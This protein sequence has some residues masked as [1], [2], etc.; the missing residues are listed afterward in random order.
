MKDLEDRLEILEAT[1]ERVSLAVLNSAQ[2]MQ[3]NAILDDLRERQYE[4]RMG[5]DL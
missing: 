2:L 1:L 3:L 4:R 5:E